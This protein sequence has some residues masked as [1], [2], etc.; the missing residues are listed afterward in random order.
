MGFLCERI[1]EKRGNELVD[2]ELDEGDEAPERRM[3]IKNVLCTELEEAGE[4]KVATIKEKIFPD[5]PEMQVEL[6]EKLDKYNM[7]YET[8]Q[9][10][11]EQ[12][13]KK[14]QKQHLTTDTGIEISIPME[15]YR[16][17]D[18]VEF[19]TN[20]DGTISVLIKN[21]GQLISR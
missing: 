3:E 20:E 14:F 1:C 7:S 4:I 19:I 15:E 21:I 17:P 5:S 8:V 10:K 12:T 11:S 16:N 18:H 2:G 6:D 9:P 13:I